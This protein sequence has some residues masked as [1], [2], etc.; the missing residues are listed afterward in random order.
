MKV[1]KVFISS[2]G[3][4]GRE[5]V[6]AGHVLDRLRGDFH[7]RVTIEP[8]FWE[9]EPMRA[10]TDYPGN[11]PEPSSFDIVICIL[12]SR[13]GSP[14]NERYRRADGSPYASGTE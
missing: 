6:L 5:R 12:W 4:V 14:L 1:L 13:L 3:D 11:I 8:Y 9:H 10:V 2:P 7:R